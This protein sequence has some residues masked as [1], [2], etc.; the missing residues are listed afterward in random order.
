MP[1][2]GKKPNIEKH[3]AH[4]VNTYLRMFVLVLLIGAIAFVISHL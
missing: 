3:S 4:L 1:F 2:R